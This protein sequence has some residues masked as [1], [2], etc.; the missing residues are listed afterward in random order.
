MFYATSMI[1][2]IPNRSPMGDMHSWIPA[3][4]GGDKKSPVP[5]SRYNRE[6]E[7]L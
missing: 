6:N 2:L 1:R 7:P 4:A 5:L 3:F